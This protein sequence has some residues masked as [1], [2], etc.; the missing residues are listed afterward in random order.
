MQVM[1]EP[2]PG[3]NRNNIKEKDITL[4]AAKI[5][6]KNLKKNLLQFF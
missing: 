6:K 4:M 2:D 5:L 1:E 3:A